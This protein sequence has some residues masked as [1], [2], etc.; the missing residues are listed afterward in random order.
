[1]SECVGSTR[2]TLVPAFQDWGLDTMHVRL[3]DG[4]KSLGMLLLL[5][6]ILPPP[7]AGGWEQTLGGT[8]RGQ[9]VTVSGA[10]C[11]EVPVTAINE[12]TGESRGTKSTSDGEYALFALPPGSYRL[13]AELA[14]FRKDLGKGIDVQV[15]RNLRVNILLEVGGPSDVITVTAGKEL[16]QPDET[17]LSAVVENRRIVNY[18]V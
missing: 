17:G 16:V 5:C 11:P 7:D 12:E 9:V 3:P 14:G 8:I 15:G 2:H 4:M 6:L 13:E 10:A 18:S 1:M